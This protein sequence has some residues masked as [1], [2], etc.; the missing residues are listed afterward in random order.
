MG[1][2]VVV[3]VVRSD[4]SYFS[5]LTTKMIRRL[6][7]LGANAVAIAVIGSG[8]VRAQDF[9]M[10]PTSPAFPTDES[11]CRSLWD[12]Y[13][14]EII[15]AKAREDGAYIQVMRAPSNEVYNHWWQ[16]I[17]ETDDIRSRRSQAVGICY[18]QVREHQRSVRAEEERQRA[19]ERRSENEFSKTS[20]AVDDI[21]LD[22]ATNTR[23]PARVARRTLVENLS[24]PEDAGSRQ[25]I[26]AY[27]SILG[28]RTLLSG[29]RK[30]QSDE[31]SIQFDGLSSLVGFG[32]SPLG[33][34]NPIQGFVVEN[35]L[36]AITKFY[37]AAYSDLER[38]LA[39]F[40]AS[41]GGIGISTLSPMLQQQTASLGA[42][43]GPSNPAD[44]Y[45]RIAEIEQELEQNLAEISAEGR[46]RLEL[47]RQMREE[48]RQAALERE[49]RWRRHREQEARADQARSSY[50]LAAARE[51]ERQWQAAEQQRLAAEHEARRR[52][53]AHEQQLAKQRRQERRRQRNQEMWAGILGS[54]VQTINTLNGVYGGYGG[55]YG[56]GGGSYAGSSAY[57]DDYCELV[58]ARP[59]GPD[60]CR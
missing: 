16:L 22:A 55:G 40:D 10:L 11:E 39:S 48:Q 43:L 52:E 41:I 38:S 21:A 51:A 30:L 27:R 59:G 56:G 24:G 8:T 19:E 57:R 23:F 60:P 2:K 50:E 31:M 5:K 42:T 53:L 4:W 18:T 9:L 26:A 32:A 49:E 46:A 29:V 35:S 14:Q 6:C 37:S 58:S 3:R 54:A 36:N 25:T 28:G 17:K 12:A 34:K 7:Y 45:A 13:E 33:R 47:D 20:K 1:D 44:F 15:A